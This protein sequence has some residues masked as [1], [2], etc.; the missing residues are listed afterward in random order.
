MPGLYIFLVARRPGCRR[1]RLSR[2]ARGDRG[3]LHTGTI[4]GNVT[5]ACSCVLSTLVLVPCAEWEREF[6]GE[7]PYDSLEQCVGSLDCRVWARF[8]QTRSFCVGC[9][10]LQPPKEVAFTGRCKSLLRAVGSNAKDVPYAPQT[11]ARRDAAFLTKTLN[12]MSL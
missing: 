2:E 8:R 10:R 5:R 9:P 7:D 4:N 1:R 3:F 12:G 11:H 6:L